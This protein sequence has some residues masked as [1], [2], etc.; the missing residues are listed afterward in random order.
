M[1]KHPSLS[2][3][4][5][6]KVL[7]FPPNFPLPPKAQEEAGTPTAV[8][9]ES[10]V[11]I[12]A[13]NRF[14][15]RLRLG[16]LPTAD[17]NASR[18]A[19]FIS[20]AE[21]N[22]IWRIKDGESL[23]DFLEGALPQLPVRSILSSAEAHR[24]AESEG[25]RFPPPQYSERFV[26]V[27]QGNECG[28]V[29]VGDALHAFPPDLGQGVNAG[30]EDIMKLRES[31]RRHGHDLA[32]AL[33][34]FERNRRPDVKSLVR[35]MQVSH[36]LQ[37]K[38]Y[39]YLAL[40][41]QL[42]FIAQFLI[43]KVSFGLIYRPPFLEVMNAEFTYSEILRRVERNCKRYQLGGYALGAASGLFFALRGRWLAAMACLLAPALLVALLFE[44]TPKEFELAD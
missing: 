26:D 16:M 18:T 2:A 8:H 17:E 25:A 19:N 1:R 33:P 43:S 27:L 13:S 31:L 7:S 11:L 5:R 30:L 20:A 42:K 15:S 6:Y 41:F 36:P 12:G 44:K 4:L 37:Y 28:V 21:E 9:S 22:E 29:L 39:K 40:L 35:L 14:N 10:Y 23:L 3:G 38:Q 32:N 34:D 24:F